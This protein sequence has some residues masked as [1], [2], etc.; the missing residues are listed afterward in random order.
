LLGIAAVGIALR[1]LARFGCHVLALI[2]S[3]VLIL[4]LSA[5][6]SKPVR[7]AWRMGY[8]SNG[9]DLSRARRG[10]QELTA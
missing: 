6:I 2:C 9:D 1:Y 7:Q 8:S 3:F 4:E 5:V 10:A